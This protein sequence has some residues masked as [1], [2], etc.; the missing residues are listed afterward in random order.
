MEKDHLSRKLA[1]ILYTDLVGANIHRYPL[2]IENGFMPELDVI[3]EASSQ[4]HAK[5]KRP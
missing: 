2:K 4:E 1:V 5:T 3:E